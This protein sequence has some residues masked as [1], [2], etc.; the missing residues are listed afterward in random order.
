MTL[1]GD[2]IETFS[3]EKNKNITC[4]AISHNG[5]FLYC[6]DEDNV[7]YTFEVEENLLRNFFKIHEKEVV[8][9][10]HHPKQNILV[11]YAVDKNLIFYK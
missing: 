5:E 6:V 11:S 2:V 9:I 10:I 3:T 7:L 4:Y 8:G 1:Q